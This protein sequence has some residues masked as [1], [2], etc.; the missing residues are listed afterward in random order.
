M[1]AVHAKSRDSAAFTNQLSLT[2]IFCAC[3]CQYLTLSSLTFCCC[4]V[5]P[6]DSYSPLKFSSSSTYG[7]NDVSQFNIMYIAA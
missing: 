1:L 7:L 4:I 5:N 3:K 2:R 6:F